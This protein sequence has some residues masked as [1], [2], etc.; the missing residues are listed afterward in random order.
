MEYVESMKE[1]IDK[2]ENKL[3]KIER[4]LNNLIDTDLNLKYR[5][6][7]FGG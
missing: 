7:Y 2:G 3:Q 1:V 5:P 4:D 6:I